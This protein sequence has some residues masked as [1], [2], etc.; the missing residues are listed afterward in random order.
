MAQIVS[1][2]LRLSS[3]GPG[4]TA[5]DAPASA[6][7]KERRATDLGCGTVFLPIVDE[8][9]MPQLQHQQGKNLVR[10]VGATGEV[11]VQQF[12]HC[13]RPIETA[14]SEADG[15]QAVTN[16]IAQFRSHP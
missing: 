2:P 10:A 4:A 6:G 15:R 8:L 14:R 12:I 11:P 9:L 1:D 7:S 13:L 16:E 3:D 5:S